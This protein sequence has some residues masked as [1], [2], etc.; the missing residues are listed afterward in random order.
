LLG[1]SQ[2]PFESLMTGWLHGRF[3]SAGLLT[4]CKRG[5][6]DSLKPKAREVHPTD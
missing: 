6:T 3:V 4:G 2:L 5:S 1:S